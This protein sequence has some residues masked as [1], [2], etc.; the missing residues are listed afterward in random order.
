MP[1]PRPPATHPGSRTTTTLTPAPPTDGRGPTTHPH[2]DRLVAGA[3]GRLG[4]PA[5]TNNPEATTAK[6]AAT[7]STRVTVRP[8]ATMNAKRT[9]NG[10]ANPGKATTVGTSR[11]TNTSANPGKAATA[12]V[13]RTTNSMASPAN[14]TAVRV[15]RTM[16]GSDPTKA[17]ATSVHCATNGEADPYKATTV[18]INRDS[19]G[20]ANIGKPATVDAT[21]T[22]PDEPK[23]IWAPNLAYAPICFTKH[24]GVGGSA[25]HSGGFGGSP[26]RV[27]T[28]R[29]RRKEAKLPTSR[30]QSFVGKGG[31]E[32]PRPFGH[33]DL[34]RARLPFR[35][36]PLA[37]APVPRC[38]ERLARNRQCY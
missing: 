5:P 6:L 16:G 13:H 29:P 24:G 23:A 17:A 2:R 30:G 1:P 20:G 10:K 7:T 28:K 19:T 8:K 14:A 18:D 36:L 21:G 34:N 33:T 15:Y 25:P 9:Q 12:N 27:T 31:V 26:P 35:H 22:K 11:S 32:P 3:S 4:L 37:G 38:C